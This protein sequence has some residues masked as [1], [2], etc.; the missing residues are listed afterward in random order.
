MKKM[1]PVSKNEDTT[2]KL[3]K[4]TMQSLA[5]RA[6][7]FESKKECLERV[8]AENCGSSKETKEQL[9]EPQEESED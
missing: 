6:K 3:S 1:V 8:I 7:P 2:V 4:K 9:D 5:D